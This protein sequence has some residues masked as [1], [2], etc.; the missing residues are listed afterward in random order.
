MVVIYM[1]GQI[2]IAGMS[3]YLDP[4]RKSVGLFIV[5]VGLPVYF[6]FFDE[7]FKLKSIEPYT[8]K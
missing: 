7:R 6:F 2:F 4:M 5:L 1:S 8:R 3:F